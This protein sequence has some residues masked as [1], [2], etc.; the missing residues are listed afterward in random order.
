MWAQVSCHRGAA[1]LL[2]KTGI[3]LWPDGALQMCWGG[4][5]VPSAQTRPHSGKEEGCD[6]GV[7]RGCS[8][9]PEKPERGPGLW[10][11]ARPTP[12]TQGLQIKEQRAQPNLVS[13][14]SGTLD[15]LLPLSLCFLMC[16][17]I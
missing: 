11:C 10:Q 16:I 5:Q 9:S 3:P 17:K 15:H 13:E 12:G 8:G 6:F 4:Y 2:H 14:R 7:F 1:S